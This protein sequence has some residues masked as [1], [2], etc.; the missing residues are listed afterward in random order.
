[1]KVLVKNIDRSVI[2]ETGEISKADP[3]KYYDDVLYRMKLT[4]GAR[5]YAA[6]RHQSRS[7]ASIWAIIFLSMYVFSVSV[8]LSLHGVDGNNSIYKLLV[9][10]STV[11]SAFILAFSTLENGK[12]H[13]LKAELFLRCAQ[14]IQKL[15]DEVEYMIRTNK[16]TDEIIKKYIDNYNDLIK[17]SSEN[18]SD[19][20][21]IMFRIS[22]Y[23]Y[24][25]RWLF[26]LFKKIEYWLDCWAMVWCAIIL[27]PMVLLSVLYCQL[28]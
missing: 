5:Y 22:I 10:L 3:Q 8:F 2:S 28:Y 24:R 23:K 27:P 12:K 14:G 25:D 6:R 4:K 11:M 9:M 18:H 15:Y 16:L 26:R 17:V 20:D 1:M 13:D 21:Y 19:L 7:I